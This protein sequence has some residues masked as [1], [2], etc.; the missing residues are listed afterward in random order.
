MST[1]PTHF[2][3]WA[4]AT[5]V[6]L[7]AV[8]ASAQVSS[9]IVEPFSIHTESVGSADL[10]GFTT[11]RIYA[12]LS[13][14]DDFVQAVFGSD[15]APLAIATSTSFWQHPAGG[16]LGSEVNPFM[17][18]MFPEVAYDSWLTI[19]L[20]QTP[21]SGAGVFSVGMESAL[22]TFA[23]GG[24]I[25][26]S[27]SPGGSWFVY[28]GTPHG[29]PDENLRVLVAQLTTDGSISGTLNLQVFI[30]G[31][32]TNVQQ[33]TLSFSAGL[34]G[35]TFPAACN[36][37]A[38][39][40]NFDG[41]CTYPDPGLDCDGA[42][43]TDV[44]ADGVCDE[45][46]VLGCQDV[47]ACDYNA[48]A[49]DAGDCIYPQLGYDCAGVCLE[50]ADGDGVCDPFEEA[51]CTNGEAC[52]FDASATD[53]DG[54]C[55]FAAEGYDCAGNCLNDADG[56]G[57]CD[58][59]E[60]GGC[61][62]ISACNFDDSATDE[63][64]SCTYAAV[65]YDCAGECLE[66]EDGDG[67]CDGFEVP[68]CDDGQACNYDATAT[69]NDGTCSYAEEGYDCLGTCLMDT[70]G[71]G[72]CDAFEVLGCTNGLATNFLASAT[73][74]DGSCVIEP[75]A[76]CGDGTY[77]DATVGQC[78]SDGTGDGGVGGY[79]SSCFGDFYGDGSVGANELLLFLTVYDSTC[80]GE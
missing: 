34:A 60:I 43:L 32:Q 59:F 41:S 73:D 53:E 37:N 56:D 64:G 17:A 2:G 24:D 62:D 74:D 18:N 23:G 68:G 47:E 6:V 33:E 70:D 67:V 54:S 15:D 1:H 46:E 8:T 40:T 44:D 35:C 31:S 39:A 14:A 80:T 61:M 26:I 76:Y 48:A 4:V 51:G 25:E 30:G 28:P 71:D 79:G 78:V 52:N 3:G 57:I 45:F 36:Y 69:D 7:C 16:N 65:G 29:I 20:E 42:C 72:V 75:S 10:T 19:G 58:P 13:S 27:A 66:D 49:T 77:W 50:D 63:D 22:G 55:T 5:C 9:L 11:F 38:E 21:T 12:Q